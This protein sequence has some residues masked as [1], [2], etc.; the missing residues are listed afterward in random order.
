MA[1]LH[2][3]PDLQRGGLQ[4][5]SRLWHSACTQI[6]HDN[7]GT[8]NAMSRRGSIGVAVPKSCKPTPFL[9]TCRGTPDGQTWLCPALAAARC[10]SSAIGI[11]SHL[12]IEAPISAGSSLWWRQGTCS[13]DRF[14]FWPDALL[15]RTLRNLSKHCSSKHPIYIAN[16]SSKVGHPSE[17]HFQGVFFFGG[18]GL[19]RW[20]SYCDAEVTC[21]KNAGM[22]GARH[23]QLSRPHAIG[24]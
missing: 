1:C 20:L 16:P 3:T 19:G 18:G 6:T 4:S 24:K 17:M 2:Q 8:M 10:S 21:L 12:S 14:M 11:S 15:S 9:Y 13:V 7:S 5:C 22:V 23:A